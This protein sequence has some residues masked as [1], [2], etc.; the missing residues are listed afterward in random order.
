MAD[1]VTKEKAKNVKTLLITAP[2]HIL[3]PVMSANDTLSHAHKMLK[4]HQQR[5][6][7]SLKTRD[8]AGETLFR[9]FS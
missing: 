8:P 1:G 4:N 3:P 2:S 7:M 5:F 9:F 6:K